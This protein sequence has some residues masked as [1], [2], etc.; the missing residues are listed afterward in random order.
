MAEFG[1]IKSFH[2]DHGELDR[3]TKQQCFVLGYELAQVDYLLTQPDAI[4]QPVHSDNRE[5]IEE[6]CSDSG[7]EYTLR[8]MP[9]DPGEAWMMLEVAPMGEQPSIDL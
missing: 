7:R 4:L 8:W 6:S 5:R 3:L 1:L 2:I 9:V